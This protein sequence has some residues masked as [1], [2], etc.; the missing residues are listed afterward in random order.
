[1]NFVYET[2][3]I[4]PDKQEYELSGQLYVYAKSIEVVD[5]NIEGLEYKKN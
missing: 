5:T 3:E 2:H 4:F 1:M